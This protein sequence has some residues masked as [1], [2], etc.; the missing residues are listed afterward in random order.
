MT[1]KQHYDVYIEFDQDIDNWPPHIKDMYLSYAAENTDASSAQFF[2]S[3]YTLVFGTAFKAYMHMI[4]P[5]IHMVIKRMII[6][7]EG[8]SLDGEFI[9]DHGG[10]RRYEVDA[11]IIDFI[12]SFREQRDAPEEDLPELDMDAFYASLDKETDG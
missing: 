12:N 1:A 6:L 11:S 3:Y 2:S 7:E 4:D 9:V 8:A 5:Y 10:E